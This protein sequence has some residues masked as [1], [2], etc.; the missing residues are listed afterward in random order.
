ML[1]F[2]SAT[3]RLFDDHGR[4]HARVRLE[5][6]GDLPPLP[7]GTWY[8]NGPGRFEIGRH[9]CANWLDGDGLVRALTFDRGMVTC[10]SRFVR[11]R[12]FVEEERAGR[13][14]FRAF[15][16]ATRGD[17]LNDRETGLESPANVSI[18]AHAGA[19]LALGEQGQ[20]WQLDADTLATVG[21]YDAFG[22][23]TPV[24]PFAA[25]AK[26]DP[27]TGDLF[28]FGV[29]FS[30][31]RPL[32]N[33]F[34]F[35]R[36]GHQVFRVRVP[37][38][39]CSTIHDFALARTCAAFYIT[40]YLLDIG[41]L[42]AGGTVFESL[43]WQ[44]QHGSRVL[45]VSRDTGEVVCSVPVGREYCLHTINCFEEAGALALDVIE[46]RRPVYGNYTLPRLFEDP[47][48]ARPVRLVIDTKQ[49]RLLSR[50]EL[51][52]GCAPEFPVTDPADATSRYTEFWTLGMSA[53]ERRGT[54]FF[55]QL[56]RFDWGA[57]AW[58][59]TYT[60][61]DGIFLGSEPLFVRDDADCCWLVCQ[62]FDARLSRGGFAVFAAG[63]V[64]RGPV[65]RL[66][67]DTP[68]PMAF[69]GIFVPAPRER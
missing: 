17:R 49:G 27:V 4:D 30:P 2:E 67:L 9:R 55:N 15:G 6:E 5:I 68:T 48:H 19:L 21:P 66:W 43:T 65:A 37:L 1:T 36:A 45:I 52:G 63:D 56:L 10:A 50:D 44:P 69:H 47:I 14:L 34:R 16:S 7:P 61:P 57:P 13:P 41:R 3:E 11:T 54:K 62:T 18:L 58:C 24:T 25:H 42:R 12:K 29:S 32:L 51:R 31:D 60:A 40:P 33:V 23:L 35:D 59:D 64:A 20:P 28:N 38:P 8:L 39:Y 26:I 46:M 53:G 22:A